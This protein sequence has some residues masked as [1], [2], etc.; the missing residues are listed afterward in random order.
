MP[1]VCTICSHPER[2][3]I[4]A[5]LANGE[6]IRRIA[7]RFGVSETAARRHK[8]EHIAATIAKATEAETIAADD[9]LGQVQML[10]RKALGILAS[11]EAAGSLNVA[12]A[13]VREARGNV[14]LLA[15]LTHQL[16]DRPTVNILVA[17]E[18]LTVRAVILESLRP[19]PDA[20]AAVSDR[21]AALGDGHAGG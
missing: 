18:W 5:V 2:A 17:A 7:A 20:R 3:A 11:A 19:Y 8:A 10:Q 13:A 1:R 4:D 15:K 12:L 21:L 6:P 14:E 16:S 9:L